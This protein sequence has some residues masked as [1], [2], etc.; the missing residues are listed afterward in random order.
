MNISEFKKDNVIETL[1]NTT[2]CKEIFKGFSNLLFKQS[3]FDNINFF[4]SLS[5]ECLPLAFLLSNAFK[6]ECFFS[7]YPVHYTS[8]EY[9]ILWDNVS[10]IKETEGRVVL[11]DSLIE[12][13]D[14]L[15]SKLKPLNFYEGIGDLQILCILCIKSLIKENIG[16]PVLSL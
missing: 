11:V 5:L 6:C 14:V 7:I 3:K 4:V 10:C 1:S 9:K 2:K 16:I 13:L 12:D 15:K 8:S